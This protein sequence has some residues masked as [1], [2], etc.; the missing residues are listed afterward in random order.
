MLR[1]CILLF[2]LKTT[3]GYEVEQITEPLL[4]GEGPHWDANKQLLYFV[5]ITN[6]TIHVYDPITG[7]HNYTYV[8]K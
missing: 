3:C 4:L 5:D 1:L 8:G 6:C 2:L 7:E